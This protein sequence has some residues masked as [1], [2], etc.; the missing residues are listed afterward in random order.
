MLGNK[1][2]P[3]WLIR[4]SLSD[5]V[6]G[7]RAGGEILRGLTPSRLPRFDSELHGRSW[8]APGWFPSL[9]RIKPRHV[10]RLAKA[11][12]L[13]EATGVVLAAHP[14]GWV[15]QAA[16][17]LLEQCATPLAVGMLVLRSNDWVPPIR[18]Q[19]QG[20]LEAV[21]V[22]NKA[23]AL[24]PALPLLEQ[25]AAGE[26]RS[27][28]FAAGLL[29]LMADRLPAGSLLAGLKHGDRR[30]R[31]SSARL[32]VRTGP[33]GAALD[34]A[35]EQDDAI[36]ACIVAEAVAEQDKSL[37]FSK[38]LTESRAPRLR[39][40]GLLRLL[41]EPGEV[42]EAAARK[43]LFDPSGHVRALGQDYLL[44][45]GVGVRGLYTD[46]LGSH[47]QMAILGL[48]ETGARDDAR[49]IA[50]HATH[51]S[52]RVRAAVC[53]AIAVLD[54]Q[55]HR[56]TLLA[57][58]DDRSVRVARPAAIAIVRSGATPRELDRLWSLVTTKPAGVAVLAA[59]A[60]LDRWVQLLYAFRALSSGV[61]ADAGA[62][63]LDRVLSRWNASFTSPSPDR[64]P[65]LVGML[66]RVMAS[67]DPARA[68]LLEL[69]VR[70]CLRPPNRE[71]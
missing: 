40:L 3:E 41:E 15:R 37:A 57:L 58:V 20:H 56:E 4:R 68:R 17:P 6:E 1:R 59:F 69:T 31:R 52:A 38:R 30:V 47:P 65:E 67:L 62:F 61:A 53:R 10:E 16:L 25:L 12:G 9:W 71:G 49:R 5:E 27:G 14:S 46:M 22:A 55:G 2:C 51:P 29:R 43:A 54:A 64:G 24:V 50:A 36:T 32:L 60:S 70:P 21:V 19:A 13:P 42:A 33:P 66:P 8:T 45:S 44:R 23:E 35:L 11:S 7:I 63:A 26:P 28:G 39:R 48:A 34:A 18:A